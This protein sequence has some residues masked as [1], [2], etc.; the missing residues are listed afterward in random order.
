MM[1]KLFAAA[2]V[3]CLLVA[4]CSDEAIMKANPEGT[5][6]IHKLSKR[7]G[8]IIGYSLGDSIQVRFISRTTV[9]SPNGVTI[10]Q[11]AFE[12]VNVRPFEIE[13]ADTPSTPKAN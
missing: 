11:E 12:D 7:R 3:S 9:T 1:R 4:G 8:Q 13:P 2:V 6:V 5:F 10:N